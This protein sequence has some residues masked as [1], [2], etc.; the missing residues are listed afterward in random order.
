MTGTPSQRPPTHPGEMLL[1]EFLE[2]MGLTPGD[3]ADSIY[4]PLPTVTEIIDGRQGIT[5]GDALRL[6]KFFRTTER[7]WLN[8]QM[9]WDLYHAGI[10]EA[11]TLDQIQ[12]CF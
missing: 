8:G 11:E 1:K 6:A 3:L 5:A 2:P 12:P 4:A 10:A 9:E 7:F